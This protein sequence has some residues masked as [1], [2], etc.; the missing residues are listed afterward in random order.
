MDHNLIIRQFY[1]VNISKKGVWI[2]I[3]IPYS[4]ENKISFITK[5]LRI[6]DEK[7]EKNIVLY[8]P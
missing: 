2:L 4:L 8:L 5:R 1:G 6:L 7:F 3:R